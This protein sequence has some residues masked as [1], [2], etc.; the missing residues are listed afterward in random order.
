MITL[1]IVSLGF[2][3]VG[4]FLLIQ[5]ST[6]ILL[7]KLKEVGINYQKAVLVSPQSSKESKI[8]GIS[9]QDEAN[10]SYFVSD[11]KREKIPD[12]TEFTISVPKLKLD[13]GLVLVESNDLANTI[14]HL[15]GSSLPGEKGNVFLSAHSAINF[16]KGITNAPFA[17]LQ[18][19]QKGDLIEIFAGSAKFAYRVIDLKVVKPADLSVISSPEPNGRYISLMT[20][21]PPGLNLKRLVVLGK[22]I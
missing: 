13:K 21:V 16:F 2:L 18:N 15:P 7:F 10:F 8:L 5:I 4:I 14:S 17:D 12:Y 22:M 3:F 9:I 19:L 20:C 1:K 11:M 6:P